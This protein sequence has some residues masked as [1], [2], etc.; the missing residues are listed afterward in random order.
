VKVKLRGELRTSQVNLKVHQR[1]RGRK[2]SD[3]RGAE[4]SGRKTRGAVARFVGIERGVVSRA[5]N[6][7]FE[8]EWTMP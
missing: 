2:R 4:Y 7:E 5:F 3:F 8:S 1:R 6:L